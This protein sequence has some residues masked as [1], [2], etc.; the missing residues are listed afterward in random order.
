MI[1]L[2]GTGEG[3]TDPAGQDGKIAAPPYPKPKLSVSATVGGSQA[4]VQY[5]G[6]APGW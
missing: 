1:V 5:A 6:A 3:Q 2:Y 4:V